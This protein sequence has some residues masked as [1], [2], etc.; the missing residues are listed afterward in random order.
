MPQRSSVSSKKVQASIIAEAVDEI[1]RNLNSAVRKVWD[2]HARRDC[3]MLGSDVLEYLCILLVFR[4]L[5]PTLLPQSGG[6]P[7]LRAN[8]ELLGRHRGRSSRRSISTLVVDMVHTQQV[9][10][11]RGAFASSFETAP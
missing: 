2:G 1:C 6:H 10:R 9:D 8:Q 3:E 11:N 7:Y 5:S 4:L